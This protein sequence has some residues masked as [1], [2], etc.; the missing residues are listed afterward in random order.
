VFVTWD[1]SSPFYTNDG[2]SMKVSTTERIILVE[3]QQIETT[4]VHDW[5]DITFFLIDEDNDKPVTGAII[6]FSCVNP[7]RTLNVGSE[8]TLVERRPW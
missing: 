7:A 4:P 3:P 8:Y 6:V 1:G 2:T 5:M